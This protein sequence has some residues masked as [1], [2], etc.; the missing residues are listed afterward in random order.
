M[1]VAWVIQV[2]AAVGLVVIAIVVGLKEGTGLVADGRPSAKGSWLL[3]G[4][5][6]L[7]RRP[8]T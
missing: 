7:K 4:K 1:V 3:T 8:V 6:A 2:V 5:A